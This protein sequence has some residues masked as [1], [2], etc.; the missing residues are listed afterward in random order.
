VGDDLI[1]ATGEAF[2]LGSV[3]DRVCGSEACDPE[4]PS[5]GV[6]GRKPPP[7]L[8]RGARS[9]SPVLAPKF[10]RGAPRPMPRPE[11]IVV[12]LMLTLALGAPLTRRPMIGWADLDGDGLGA[13]VYG[14]P[15]QDPAMVRVETLRSR[16]GFGLERVGRSSEPAP[17]G[18]IE[19]EN[20][21]IW[22]GDGPWADD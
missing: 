3:T 13:P 1:L 15:D 16:G 19:A 17:R 11:V 9:T 21:R 2:D 5:W 14:W 20:G 18:R 4:P 10:Q 12:V 8:W 22:W 6:D 7:T